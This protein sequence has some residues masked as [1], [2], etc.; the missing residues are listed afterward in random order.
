MLPAELAQDITCVVGVVTVGAVVLAVAAVWCLCTDD[1]CGDA[2]S[3]DAS[4]GDASGGDADGDPCDLA[5]KCCPIPSLEP[6]LPRI[7]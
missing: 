7:T 4:G 3:G 2:S 6:K 5:A 1:G